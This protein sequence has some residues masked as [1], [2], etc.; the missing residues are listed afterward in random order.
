[1]LH[2]TM[3]ENFFYRGDLPHWQ[4]PEGTFFITY[5]LYGSIPKPVI[6]KLKAEYE[7]A[8][9][10]INE[11]EV[12]LEL[13]QALESI[14]RKK[15]YVEQKRLFKK[16]DDF[17]DSN[18]NEP[19]W[20][21]NPEVSKLVTESIHHG[22]EKQ[23]KLWAF[24][25]MSNHVHILLRMLSGAPI[26]WKV[27]QNSKKYTGRMAN[28]I[29]CREGLKFWEKESYDHLV[30]DEKLN[31]PGEFDR[32]LRYILNNPVKAGL[33]ENWEDWPLTFCAPGLQ[34]GG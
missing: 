11:E 6:E 24:C 10:R 16:I 2:I 15:Q 8:M 5:R 9:L 27:L 31:E 18:L 30:R 12:P 25:I 26:L 19:H 21:K 3:N 29:L 4:P 28:R 22:D 17:L 13:N 14:H 32:I 34:L 20:L 1:M 7:L 23:Y 33:V